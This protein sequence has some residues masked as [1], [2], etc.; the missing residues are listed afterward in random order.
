MIGVQSHGECW[1]RRAGDSLAYVFPLE[2]MEHSL[3]LWNEALFLSHFNFSYFLIFHILFECGWQT[4]LYLFQ[5]YNVVTQLLCM[6]FYAHL[7]CS[8]HLSPHNTILILL[9]IFPVLCLLLLWL[10]HSQTGACISHFTHFAIP[11][12]FPLCQPSICCLYLQVWFC[13][14]FLFFWIPPMGEITWDQ[15]FFFFF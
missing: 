3:R 4:T 14:L 9:T 10:I 6:L 1:C 13:F 8:S 11:Y 15:C 5:K 2:S 7:K 12:P